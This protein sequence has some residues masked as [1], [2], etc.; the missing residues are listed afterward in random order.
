MDRTRRCELL[1]RLP[2]AELERLGSLVVDAS[3]T[4]VVVQQGPTAGMV[5]ARAV[6]GA[7][8]ETFNL[9]EILV[10][11]CQVSIGPHEGWSIIIG[12]RPKGS[13]WAAAID[14]ALAGG[15][16]DRDRL[17]SELQ[18]LIARQDEALAAERERLSATMVRFE[19]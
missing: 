15:H 3:R 16:P 4:D 17:D 13:F 8:G 7:R 12:S 5:M 19:T 11:E 10:T 18:H 6:E 1:A 9:G 2:D 14:A